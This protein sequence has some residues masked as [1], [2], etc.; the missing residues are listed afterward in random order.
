MRSENAT[1]MGPSR[2][3]LS[4]SCRR[5]RRRKSSPCRRISR[6]CRRA[7]PM[8]QNPAWRGKN[9]IAQD[10]LIPVKQPRRREVE[11]AVRREVRRPATA[12]T[13]RACRSA[14]RRPD[15]C[16]A[17]IRGTT[18]AGAARVYTLAGII[19][20]AMPYLDPGSLSDEAAQ[21]IAA[22]IN[23]RAAAALSVQGSR[24]RR[25]E[26]PGRRRLT[27]RR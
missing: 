3:Y 26:G 16:G 20:Y 22:Y 15:R 5:R 10:K 21:Q 19:R 24:L 14:T 9:A 8:G 7:T 12:S 4:T 11:S 2:R 13:A 17:I 23:A 25:I 18:G 6:G 1:G 27:T